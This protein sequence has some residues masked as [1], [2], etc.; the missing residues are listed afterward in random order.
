MIVCKLE[1]WPGGDARRAY[2]LGTVE[3]AN[4][5]GTESR[6][7]YDVRLHRRDGRGIWRRASVSGFP[8]KAL[9]AYDLLMRALANAIGPRNSGAAELINRSLAEVEREAGQ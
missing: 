6:G 3:I 2:P 5:G 1:M 4:V 8:R 9:G 7:D